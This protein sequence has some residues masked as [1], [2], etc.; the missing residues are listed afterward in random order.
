MTMLR[1]VGQGVV[2]GTILVASMSGVY[3]VH[4]NALGMSHRTVKTVVINNK[5]AFKAKTLTIKVG[6]KVTWANDTHAPHTVTH[7]SKNWKISK[8][9]PEHGKVSFTFAKRG[10]FT[11]H[12]A[13]HPYMHGK[14]IV[15]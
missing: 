5:Y 11:Y 4:A 6:T 9:L 12:C 13:I 15:K 10:T 2:V 8:Q 7:T 14:I 1:T 3:G